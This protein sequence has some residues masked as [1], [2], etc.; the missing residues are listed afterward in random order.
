MPYLILKEGNG[1]NIESSS[2]SI[3]NANILEEKKIVSDGIGS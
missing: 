3:A 1:Y 2:T